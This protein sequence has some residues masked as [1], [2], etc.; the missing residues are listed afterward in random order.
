M[1]VEQHILYRRAPRDTE[2][3]IIARGTMERMLVVFCGLARR[4]REQCF[5]TFGEKRFDFLDVH[6]MARKAGLLDQA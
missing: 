2:D 5:M 4:E 1:A 3:K 6:N